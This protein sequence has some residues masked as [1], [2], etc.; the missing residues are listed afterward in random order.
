MPRLETRIAALEAKSQPSPRYNADR[1]ATDVVEA[2][3]EILSPLGL[4]VPDPRPGE[5]PTPFSLPAC[6][7]FSERRCA[8]RLIVN[9]VNQFSLKCV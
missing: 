5:R 6:W 9:P 3:R 4:E 7:G 1:L 8:L 2:F